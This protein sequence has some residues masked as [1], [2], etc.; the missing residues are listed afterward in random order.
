[1]LSLWKRELILK[2]FT[3]LVFLM[4]RGY[5]RSLPLSHGAVIWS[6]IVAV[7]A[8]NTHFLCPRFFSKK[9]Y[10]NFVPTSV[11]LPSVCP[12]VR[13]SV[14]A[15]VRPSVMFLVNA[16]PPKPLGLAT[17]NFTGV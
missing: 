15:W 1:M 7:P 11:S 6:V 10:I 9:G 12:P 14:C 8:N 3:F 17:S 4:P 5:Y 16:S 13:P 2:I